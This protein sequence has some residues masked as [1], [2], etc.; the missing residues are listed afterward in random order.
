MILLW[1]Q[2]IEL[3]VRKK[4]KF[5]ECRD[6]GLLCTGM[7]WIFYPR[8]STRRIRKFVYGYINA[9]YDLRTTLT[10]Q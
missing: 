2:L 7:R 3:A 9:Q 6:R 4:Q 5:Y 1:Q 10:P 8:L